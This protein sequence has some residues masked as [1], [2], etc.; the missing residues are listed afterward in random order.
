MKKIATLLAGAIIALASTS[1]IASLSDRWIDHK[2]GTLTDKTTGIMWFRC[3]GHQKWDNGKCTNIV[4]NEKTLAAGERPNDISFITQDRGVPNDD[5]MHS[6]Q[7]LHW[8][9]TM[10]VPRKDSGLITGYE[11]PYGNAVMTHVAFYDLVPQK[12]AYTVEHTRWKVAFVPEL[13]SIRECD[14]GRQLPL[15]YI[16]PELA[17]LKSYDSVRKTT[18]NRE[19]LGVDDPDEWRLIEGFLELDN[20]TDLERMT[21]K[22]F[23]NGK[24][25][26]GQEGKV[27]GSI[28]PS[29]QLLNI[30][31]GCSTSRRPTID[32]VAFPGPAK[33]DHLLY[34]INSKLHKHRLWQQR[35]TVKTG[36]LLDFHN[37]LP[38]LAN[39]DEHDAYFRKLMD[40]GK[41]GVMLYRVPKEYIEDRTSYK[42]F[43]D[44]RKYFYYHTETVEVY[45]QM[46]KFLPLHVDRGLNS[47]FIKSLSVFMDDLYAQAKKMVGKEVEL[48]CAAGA[49]TVGDPTVKCP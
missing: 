2:D 1:A 9:S 14:R 20:F 16:D 36:R 39:W 31:D 42:D 8:G 33:A 28:R 37:D 49:E 46:L 48:L 17:V 12:E 11:W 23:F 22:L 47:A 25:V 38:P 34:L 27:V 43:R 15:G 7:A 35:Y 41:A 4:L 3:L 40:S 24:F 30:L 5:L 45:L 19:Y 18:V 44:F 6:S 10:P 13:A 29:A 26:A 21:A 32:P